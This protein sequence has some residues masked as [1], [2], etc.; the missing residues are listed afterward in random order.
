MKTEL[1][2]TKSKDYW[3]DIQL[4]ITECEKC[5]KELDPMKSYPVKN[6]TKPKT[7]RAYIFVCSKCQIKTI[8]KK[9][10]KEGMWL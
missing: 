1:L 3:L 4:N 5:K 6:Y 2:Y 9:L 10:K 8:Q 7:L